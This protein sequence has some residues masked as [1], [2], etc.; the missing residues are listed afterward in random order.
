MA[1]KGEKKRRLAKVTAWSVGILAGLLV[2]AGAAVK[3]WYAPSVIRERAALAVAKYWDGPIRI[4]S[5][6]FN[7]F[8]ATTLR[9]VDLLDGGGRR[10]VRLDSISF[11]L[12]DWPGTHP[13]LEQIRIE[14]LVV[15]ACR[16]DGKY[17]MPVKAFPKG[18][19]RLKDYMDLKRIS[20]YGFSALIIDIAG[21]QTRQLAVGDGQNVRI[22]VRPDGVFDV[23]IPDIQLATTAPL[24]ISEIQVHEGRI[25][26][27]KIE[28]PS[29]TFKTCGGDVKATFYAVTGGPRKLVY[30]GRATAEEIDLSTLVRSI[31]PQTRLARGTGLLEIEILGGGLELGGLWGKGEFLMENV[32][33]EGVGFYSFI[34][35]TIGIDSTKL[36]QSNEIE[37]VFH[38]AGPV[39]TL[40][41]AKLTNPEIAMVAE[42]GGTINLH[43]KQM[44]FYVV[45]ARL[46][47]LRQTRPMAELLA[48]LTRFRVKG[49]W[50]DPAGKLVQKETLRDIGRGTA[51][52]FADSLA[53]SV[54]RGSTLIARRVAMRAAGLAFDWLRRDKPVENNGDVHSPNTSQPASRLAS[55][56]DLS[57]DY[58]DRRLRRYSQDEP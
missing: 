6:D 8:G 16:K 34:L 41:K 44:D 49:A 7:Y 46:E 38:L 43:T 36:G 58:R 30:G 40:E 42:P 11:D 10:W 31:N 19:S 39:L 53:G 56:D 35:K 17:E 32:D 27:G 5:V 23:I 18:P 22:D 14:N 12:R 48:M 54:V 9:D 24:K 28:A 51:E 21:M 20:V 29:L 1:E 15:T 13:M 37:G 57:D 45:H 4:G 55:P 2:A 50:T 47:E 3:Y 33:L 52:Y 26:D 25:N